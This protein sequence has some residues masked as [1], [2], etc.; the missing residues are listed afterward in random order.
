MIPLFTRPALSSTRPVSANKADIAAVPID[1]AMVVGIDVIDNNSREAM[2]RY[3]AP[4]LRAI[5]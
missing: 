1:M 2:P 5:T 4:S 3:T